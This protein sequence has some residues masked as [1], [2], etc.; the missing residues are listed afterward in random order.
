MTNFLRF[1]RRLK[2]ALHWCIIAMFFNTF[3]IID[4]N[5]VDLFVWNIYNTF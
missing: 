5:F 4:L 3:V 1:N 2:L